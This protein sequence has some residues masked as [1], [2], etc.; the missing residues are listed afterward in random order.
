[1]PETI[2]ELSPELMSQFQ[3]ER[4]VLL[5]TVDAERGGP[6]TSA[7]SWIYAVN[8]K[9]V[10]FALDARSRIVSNI[11]ANGSVN[12]CIF[13]EGTVQAVYGTAKIVKEELEG[14]P[15]KLVCIDIDVDTVRDAMFYGARISVEP[16]YE[17]TYDKRAAE[18]LDNQ[19]FSAMKKA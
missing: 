1:M 10:R 5:S 19:V 14:V 3:K 12:V 13:A 15:F 17:K 9:L 7:I 8:G 6:S 2:T 4:L 18:K 11:R 16:E